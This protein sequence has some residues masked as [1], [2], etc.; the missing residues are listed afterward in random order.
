VT[1]PIR[2]LR[3]IARLNVGG[4]ALHVSYLTSELDKIGYE[5]TLVAGRVGPTEGSMDYVPAALGVEPHY[6]PELGRDIAV[7]ADAAAVRHVLSLIRE[8]RPHIL[9]T[10]TAKAGAVGRTA[11]ILAGRAR[12]Q[13]VVHT[14]HGHVLRGYFGPLQTEAFKQLERNLARSTDA[15]IA[16]SPE[17]RDDLV[18]L[19]IAAPEKIAVIRLGLDLSARLRAQPGAR[20]QLRTELGITGD[21][22]V[23][24]WLGRMTE[25]KRADRLLEAFALLSARR[26]D[27]YLLLVGDGP[28]RRELEARAAALGI[29]GRCRFVGFRE[30][31]ATVFA[32]SDVVALT[33]A[34]EG[35][36]VSLIEASASGLPIVST[37][38]G[39]VRDVVVDGETG[40]LLP[41][42]DPEPLAERLERLASDRE[43]AR[44]L[45][46]AGHDFVVP[47]YSVPRLVADV[48]S[49]YRELLVRRPEPERKRGV[50][51]APNAL[52][53]SLPLSTVAA[54]AE[55]RLR[56]LL[57]SQYFP[58][59]IGATQT[60]IQA[61]AEYLADRGHD[62]TV[63]C[64]FPNHP[65]GVIPS[66][67]R[68]RI[69]EDDRSNSYR[70]LR[71]WV[72]AHEEKTQAT[73]LSFYLSFMALA[74]AVSPLV[75]DVDVV[76]ATS[77]PLFTGLAGLFIARM[78]RAPF[79]LDVRDLWPAAATS[80]GQISPGL[81]T[82][83]GLWLERFLYRS[84][85]QVVAVTQPFC[86]H[87]DALRG[88]AQPASRL[89]P[90]GTLDLFFEE[91]ERLERFGVPPEQFLVTFAGTHGIAQALPSVL[92]AAE[93]LNGE[94]HFA[95]V[96]D[97]P[98]KGIVVDDA[99]RRE[100]RNVSF[101][102]QVPLEE[103]LP[104]LAGAD[105]LLVPLSAHPTFASFVPS[106]LM[107]FMAVGR[108]VLVSASG[109]AARLTEQ[110]G[111]GVVVA[112][113][114]PDALATA[115]ARLAGNP[116]Q[117]RE[118]GLRGKQFAR[119][120]LRSEQARE[121]EQVL[122]DVVAMR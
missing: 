9:H 44:R 115:V 16:V 63:I 10:H 103:I 64:E 48:D 98:V 62:V 18:S 76:I 75:G 85:A 83:S 24:T 80:L 41:T 14:F 43:L 93:R 11:A 27:A 101:H 32:A 19:G 109:E 35:T 25:I 7:G 59:E 58:P 40:F 45:G 2:I 114:D 34:N 90:N 110:S 52:P 121:L 31:V 50:K 21:A 118:M 22:F 97:G 8:I 116:A 60:R 99:A 112:P 4:P 96:G 56:V 104:A 87:I 82:R 36:P 91:P 70:V 46:A 65:Q 92:D 17:V 111:A 66:A 13:A 74:T 78:K 38:A 57:L 55:R 12:P 107:D 108:P 30:D 117:G 106:K 81:V 79:V 6:L 33:S 68:G 88:P 77:P 102:P 28:L 73:R 39:G 72:R 113:E 94:A 15:L 89:I 105:A 26:D 49:L 54:V 1:E 69:Y 61:F 119:S 53:R 84:A 120:Q 122:L 3:V 71:V 86:E 95:F 20:E 23:V 100:L 29:D 5:T 42:A 47:R 51:V 67:Y 37:D